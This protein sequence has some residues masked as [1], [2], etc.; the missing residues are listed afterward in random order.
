MGV[1]D[2]SVYELLKSEGIPLYINYQLHSKVFRFSDGSLICGSGNAT[3]P[4][5]GLSELNNIE[6]AALVLKTTLR[7][8][9]EF[10]KLRD[11]CLR[12]DD[13]IYSEFCQA[14]S[15]CP[16]QPPI[17]S[18]DADIYERYRD[19]NLYLLSDLPATSRPSDLIRGIRDS[20]RIS[21]LS[22]QMVIDCV[23]FG[24]DE[25]MSS[26]NAIDQLSAGF[27]SSQFVRV[28]VEEI[29][30]EGSMSFG[31]MTSFVHRYCRDV[32]AP[33]RSEV[34][35]TVKKLYN[36]LCY[37]FEDLSWDIPGARSQVIRTSRRR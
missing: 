26:K 18:G 7:D 15:K 25:S 31:A 10:K 30:K 27:R 2:L 35:R 19:D 24:V 28:V 29:R 3:S 37:F 22:E 20:E 4:G 23:T 36:W 16:P 5:L 34:K 21:S 13:D 33:Y 32:P 1:S 9:L 14:V 8:E 11:S 12:V 17:Q 6:T